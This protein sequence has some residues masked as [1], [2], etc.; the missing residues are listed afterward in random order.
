MSHL[1]WV[2]LSNIPAETFKKMNFFL[3]G[4]FF[5]NFFLWYLIW[6][7]DP[8]KVPLSPK[9]RLKRPFLAILFRKSRVTPHLHAPPRLIFFTTGR[10]DPWEIAIKKSDTRE[11]SRLLFGAIQVGSVGQ[12]YHFF[13]FFFR[14][15]K[16]FIFFNRI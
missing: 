15:F 10:L 11:F 1:A 13:W 9:N 8:K 4:Y 5:E 16:I 7:R 2:I 3:R 14:N 6:P 12:K